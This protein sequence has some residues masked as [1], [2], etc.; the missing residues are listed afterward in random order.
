MIKEIY[1]QP[2]VLKNIESLSEE[3]KK[4]TGF[5]KKAKGVFFIGSG[6]AFNASEGGTPPRLTVNYT[7]TLSQLTSNYSSSGRIFAEWTN[8]T[9]SPYTINW[10][11]I[12]IP[13]RLIFFLGMS[14]FFPLVVKRKRIW[15]KR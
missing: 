5:I 6:T 15:K 10:N 12:I 7:T 13:E 14:V 4:L 8:G 9:S 11:Y 2:R 3:I 1:E